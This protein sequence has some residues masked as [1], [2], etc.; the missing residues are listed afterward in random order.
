MAVE[1]AAR[2]KAGRVA[3]DDLP[4][5]EWRDK[6]VALRREQF[7][8][9]AAEALGTG[10]SQTQL[11]KPLAIE[12]AE[13]ETAEF[14][15]LSEEALAQIKCLFQGNVRTEA[16]FS[17]LGAEAR[18]YLEKVLGLDASAGAETVD[19]P[20]LGRVLAMCGSEVRRRRRLE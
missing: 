8:A 16:A 17:A 7:A 2:G 9:F 3:L 18:A 14:A 19:L 13:S 12:G 4:G 6:Q 1:D 10:N 20:L 15:R 11:K 5:K